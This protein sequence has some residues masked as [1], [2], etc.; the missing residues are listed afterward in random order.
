M[1]E[2][3]KEA[4]QFRMSML[5]LADMSLACKLIRAGIC[6]LFSDVSQAGS[7]VGAPERIY[8]AFWKCR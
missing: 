3:G 2:Q 1:E 7:V 5:N 6:V 8:F 4:N